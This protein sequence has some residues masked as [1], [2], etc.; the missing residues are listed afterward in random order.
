MINMKTENYYNDENVPE[1]VPGDPEDIDPAKS[2]HTGNGFK[3]DCAAPRHA[4]M[5]AKKLT[6]EM[7]QW[8]QDN[9]DNYAFYL[10]HGMLHDPMLR[11]SLLGVPVT[12]DDFDREEHALVIGS[13]INATKIA[14][15]LGTKVPCPPSYEFLR[16]YLEVAARTESADDEIVARAV[17][18]IREMQDPSYTEQHYCI[19]PYFEAW[20]GSIR[21]KKAAR[22]IQRDVV[23]D[24]HGQIGVM[25]DALA[26]AREA[27]RGDE[28]DPYL[29]VIN[30]TFE[31]QPSRRPTGIDGLD[32]CL[33]G[34]WGD[35]ECY[36]MFGGTSAGKSIAAGQCAWH[37][38]T[39]NNGYALIVSTELQPSE[40]V[41]RMVSCGCKIPI[42]LIQDCANLAQIRKATVAE[43]GRAQLEEAFQVLKEH[44]YVAKVHPDDGLDP[45]AI[46]RREM[47]RYEKIYGRRPTLVCLDWLGSVADI[48][49]GSSRG[50][51]E[52][53]AQWEFA[54]NG[55]VKFA[56]ETGI[57][58]LVLAQA[59]NDAQTK[60]MLTIND[61]GISKGIGKNMTAV[62][63]LT[64]SINR[65]TKGGSANSSSSVYKEEQ[66]LCVCK[67]RKGEADNIP[68]Q[69]EF[70][71][72]R[73]IARQ[74]SPPDGSSESTSSE[75][76]RT[77]FDYPAEVTKVLA[78]DEVLSHTDLWK[79]ISVEFGVEIAAAKNRIKK[80]LDL[81]LIEKTSDKK[82]RRIR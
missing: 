37:E 55:C 9:R 8:L 39:Q 3:E 70:H 27:V 82:Y 53:A 40:Y 63:G 44:V 4:E 21:A 42:H 5:G 71:Y 1:S 20:Y 30:S 79:R 66:W 81:D 59:V 41:A 49:G 17:K 74:E 46:L 18:L 77:R 35:G 56:E 29:K 52:R 72:Q 15:H 10:L 65:N 78:P 7:A 51:S 60:G 2:T 58:T 68:V 62:I 12:P 50:S 45:R 48:G 25:Q 23:P 69:R 43:P 75:G 6:K 32:R 33:N 13:L 67:A 16:S 22:R 34:G 64:N 31:E 47:L 38:V 28:D 61:I 57:P 54:A 24:V 26:S 80:Y 76:N 19:K 36:M 73:F 11:A 14:N